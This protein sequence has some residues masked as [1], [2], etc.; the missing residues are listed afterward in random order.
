M[1]LNI[2][3]STQYTLH[4]TVL[5]FNQLTH[6]KHS[7]Q[8]TVHSTQYKLKKTLTAHKTHSSLYTVHRQQQGFAPRCVEA[9][10]LGPKGTMIG[11]K[12]KKTN[13]KH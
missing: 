12:I 13:K 3:H 8:S 11:Y 5:I 1:A 2:I 6:Y 4:T 7:T 10:S 9:E